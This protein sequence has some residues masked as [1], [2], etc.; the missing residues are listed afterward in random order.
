MKVVEASCTNCKAKFETLESVPKN[1]LSC[2]SCN[3]KE[4]VLKVTNK[5]FEGGCGGGCSDCASCGQ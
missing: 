5:E 2:P 4:L 1:M 3:S